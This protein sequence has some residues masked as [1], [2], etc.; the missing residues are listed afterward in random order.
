LLFGQDQFTGVEA[1][2]DINEPVTAPAW[3]WSVHGSIEVTDPC[4]ATTL[5]SVLDTHASTA[6][7]ASLHAFRDRD[8]AAM[9][10]IAWWWDRLT[11]HTAEL[12]LL[13]RSDRALGNKLGALFSLAPAALGDGHHEVPAATLAHAHDLALHVAHR[14]SAPMRADARHIA[15][16][17]ATIS[18]RR[19]D[20]V[21]RVFRSGR[22]H[23]SR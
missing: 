20:Q 4:P 5:A 12:A 1:H 21:E 6:A 15:T 3:Q 2:L 18:D 14:G 22:D 17:L 19:L 16:M 23:L 7:I 8:V 10:A 13:A 11:R 9:P